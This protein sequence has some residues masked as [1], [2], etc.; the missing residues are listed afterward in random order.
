M[1]T[2]LPSRGEVLIIRP[3]GK[4]GQPLQYSTGYDLVSRPCQEA[5]HSKAGS[6]RNAV[7]TE[8]S[9]CLEFEEYDS[10]KDI[11]RGFKEP[12]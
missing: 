7:R 9:C 1:G 5:R 12:Y 11:S 4:E 10:R 2:C 8:C 6:E 3:T